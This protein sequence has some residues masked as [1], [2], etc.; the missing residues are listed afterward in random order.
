MDHC[1]AI[2]HVGLNS[3]GVPASLFDARL[4]RKKPVL[5]PRDEND[6]RAVFRKNFRKTEAKPAGGAG[7]ERY[8]SG[9]IEKLG[10]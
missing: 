2:E 1:R 6:S 10:S 5:S 3:K 4:Q 9:N 8:L 7:D